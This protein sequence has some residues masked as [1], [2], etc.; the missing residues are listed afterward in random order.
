ME[1]ARLIKGAVGFVLL[2]LVG[3][4]CAQAAATTGQPS[5]VALVIGN[6]SYAQAR[7]VNATSDARAVADALRDGGFDVAFAED[8]QKGQIEAS[9]ATF[10]QR[11]ERGGVA[12]VYFSG[13]AIQYQGR[14][15]LVP[16]D[17]KIASAADVRREA[18]DV[19]LILDPLIVARPR[20]SVV[21]LDAGRSNPWQ[22][23]V[24][25]R[26]QGLA[27]DGPIEG[28]V[29]VYPAA[30]GSVV[31]SGNTFAAELV[32]AMRTPGL[33]FENV[34]RRTRA[35]V[36]RASHEQQ[37]P[38]ESA[39]V[40][41]ELVV[42]PERPASAAS[43]TRPPDPVE[44]GFWTT[45]KNS[46]AVADFQAYLDSYPEG[47]FAKLARA[48]LK[49][50]GAGEADK[51]S[52][53]PA[54]SRGPAEPA[55]P[56]LAAEA[57]QAPPP[58]VAAKPASGLASA[59]E[60]E[61]GDVFHDCPECCEMVVV[62]AGEFDMG[63][64][65]PYEKPEHRVT[66]ATTFAIARREVTFDEFDLCVS[67]GA[68]RQRPDDHGWGRGTQP[69]IDVSWDDAKA[70][71][72]WL[73]QRTGRKYRLPSE[74][75]WEYAARGGTKTAFWWGR[76]VGSGQA[77]CQDCGGS[78]QHRTLPVGTFRP[79]GFGLFDTSGNAAEWV[80]DCWNDTYRNAPRDGS[81]WTN[82][83]CRQRVLRG[84]SFDSRATVIRPGARFRYDQDV[85]Y[86]ANGFRVARDLR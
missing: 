14:N 26:I 64:D 8:A 82:G 2:W 58:Q 29:L 31:G 33:T 13:H 43:Q 32:K 1:L 48:R 56:A 34:F 17:A 61:P 62:P 71:V 5:R 44:L 11:L 15:F 57:Q 83:Q 55:K 46:D 19:D 72:G 67:A 77:N 6:G 37:A 18:I 28:V 60:P 81:A 9:I 21:I 23:A 73:S 65:A 79:N 70:F 53:G 50:L 22:Q 80:E 16:L 47:Q 12:V 78:S 45:I 30:P 74:A 40:S 35:A 84:G 54:T 20:G 41:N 38:W 42:T 49:Q 27:A 69:V 7:L 75:E 39:V 66:I 63:G 59:V 24:S 10:A 86:Y 3:V 85:R 36:L 68:C 4:S 51:L 25:G 52:G 76:D